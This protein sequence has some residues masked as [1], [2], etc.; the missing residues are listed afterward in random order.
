MFKLRQLFGV[1]LVLLFL[2]IDKASSFLKVTRDGLVQRSTFLFLR[3]LT[4][5]DD[6]ALQRSRVT[7]LSGTLTSLCRLEVQPTTF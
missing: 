3:K 1:V 2:I 6:H 5:N 7:G 4:V